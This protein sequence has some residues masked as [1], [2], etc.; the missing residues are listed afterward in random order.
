MSLLYVTEYSGV[1]FTQVGGAYTAVPIEPPL[2]EYKVDFSGGVASSTTF[3]T[4]TI[5]VRLHSDAICS[6]S[7]GLTPTATTSMG[8]MAA[9]QTE[10]HGVPQASFKVSV[11]A[12]V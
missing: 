2:A 8:R 9:S 3:N 5:L 10:Y 7:F 6:V 11:I 12:N 4:R 1:G